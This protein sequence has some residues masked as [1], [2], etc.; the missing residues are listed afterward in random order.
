[1]KSHNFLAVILA[2]ALPIVLSAAVPKNH[3]SQ[4]VDGDQYVGGGTIGFCSVPGASCNAKV[5]PVKGML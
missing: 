1:M 2:M 3:G 4:S 5:V